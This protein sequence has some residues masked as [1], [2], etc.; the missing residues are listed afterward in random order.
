MCKSEFSLKGLSTA[1]KTYPV[2]SSSPTNG[3]L[4]AYQMLCHRVP[5]RPPVQAIGSEGAALDCKVSIICGAAFCRRLNHAKMA[6]IPACH[7]SNVSHGPQH[8]MNGG[9]CL[10]S[11]NRIMSADDGCRECWA[12]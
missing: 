10:C 1:M 11:N 8:G 2:Q 6:A 7:M 12:H 4:H 5:R 9:F 3:C